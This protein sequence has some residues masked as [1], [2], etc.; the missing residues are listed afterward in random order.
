MKNT[1]YSKIAETYN[2]SKTRHYIQPDPNIS[3]LIYKKKYRRVLDIG[4]G[5]GNYLLK[6][7]AYFKNKADIQWFGIEPSEAMFSVLSES[8]KDQDI[9]TKQAAAEAIPFE[10]DYFDY[11]I[12]NHSYHHFVDKEKAFQEIYRV[13]KRGGRYYI[14][15][16]HPYEMKKSWVYQFFPSVYEEDILRFYP[17]EKLFQTLEATGF[18]TRVEKRVFTYRKSML[19]IQEEAA[20]R[21]YSQLHLISD[22]NYQEGLQAMEAY[23]KSNKTLLIEHAKLY[24]LSYKD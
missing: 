1:D 7:K 18:E 16:I 6:Q 13:L 4:C 23:M 5:T 22:A 8:V 20:L 10:D 19:L 11:V 21:N 15:T 9:T 2:K 24:P 14:N 12:C 17:E 3:E